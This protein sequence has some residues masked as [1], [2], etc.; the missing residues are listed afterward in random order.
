LLWR[1]LPIAGASKLYS[2]SS[3]MIGFNGKP[4]ED[5][6]WA[7]P[8]YNLMREAVKNQADLIAISDAD[9]TDIT[10]AIHG[11]S[12]D[13]IEKAH[14]AYVSGNMFPLFGLKPA[15][16]RLLASADDRSGAANPYAVLS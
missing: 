12:D 8:E 9:R 10:W 15:L 7:T 13:D 1:P 14:V 3:K 11:S 16:G 2:L 4:M 5:N 6:H